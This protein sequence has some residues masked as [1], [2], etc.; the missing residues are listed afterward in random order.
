MARPFTVIGFTMFFTLA[1]VFELGQKAAVVILSAAAA[2]FIFSLFFKSVRR[3]F[4]IPTACITA[5]VAVLLSFA[6]ALVPDEASQRFNDGVHTVKASVVSLEEQSGERYYTE[7]K[8]SE[9]DGEEYKLNIRLSSKSRLGFK[10]YDTVEGDLQLYDIGKTRD[11]RNYYL[12]EN[13]FMGGY[14]KGDINISQPERKPIGYYP[15]AMRA[16]I[17]NTVSRLIPGERGALATALLIGDKSNLPKSVSDSFS[18]AGISHLIAVSGLHLSIWCLFILKI[19]DVFRLRRRAGAIISAAFVI[20]YGGLGLHIFRHA[21]GLHDARYA[22]RN[23]AFKAVRFTQFPRRR[24][25]YSVL[26]QSVLRDEPRTAALVPLDSRNN[27]RLRQYRFP[28]ESV[29]RARQ[30]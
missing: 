22:P 10:P 14:A 19:F 7:L 11:A 29:Y 3:D 6:A 2:A 5:V 26:C 8:T 18:S 21:C 9:I 4:V 15:L 13:I 17:K 12:S 25:C 20:V 30:K 28:A 24:A 27:C 23:A 16:Y 1:L